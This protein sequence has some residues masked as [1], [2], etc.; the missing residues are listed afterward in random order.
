MAISFPACASWASSASS[1]STSRPQS[2]CVVVVM[3]DSFRGFGWRRAR[4]QIVGCI[5]T[6]IYIEIYRDKY[7]YLF[8]VGW[9][10]LLTRVF[11][12][13]AAAR[14]RLLANRMNRAP[15]TVVLER[16]NYHVI[17]LWQYCCRLR[18]LRPGGAGIAEKEIL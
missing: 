18:L 14:R 7:M 13:N 2:A 4:V 5:H 17:F 1:S 15:F 11:L 10:R 9:G 12:A 6:Y 8:L 16:G 3:S